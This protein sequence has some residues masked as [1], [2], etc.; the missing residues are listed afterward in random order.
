MACG[1]RQGT[2]ARPPRWRKSASPREANMRRGLVCCTC[3]YASLALVP[4]S[5]QADLL[6]GVL[7]GVTAA[8]R[9][10]MGGLFGGGHGRH[11]RHAT[12]REAHPGRRE[13]RAAAREAPA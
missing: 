7:R 9:A 3:V 5:A 6:G 10:V 2:F 1:H 12:R 8:P 11:H 13:A 4:V